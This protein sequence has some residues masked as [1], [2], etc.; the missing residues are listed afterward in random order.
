MG[1]KTFFIL[2]YKFNTIPIK[3]LAE[4]FFWK[5]RK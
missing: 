2:S 5:L 4:L 3:I 1:L